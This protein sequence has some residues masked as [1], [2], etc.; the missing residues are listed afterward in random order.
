[1]LAFIVCAVLGWLAVGSAILS[2]IN[3]GELEAQNEKEPW[4]PRKTLK[5]LELMRLLHNEGLGGLILFVLFVLIGWP[6]VLYMIYED[7]K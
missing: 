7:K 5:D 4:R 6:F 3:R 1:M 2:R